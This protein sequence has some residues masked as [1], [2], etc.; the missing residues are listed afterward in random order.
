MLVHASNMHPVM[1]WIQFH[2]DQ[3]TSW[4]ALLFQQQHATAAPQ[5]TTH[6]PQLLVTAYGCSEPVT[7]ALSP[8]EGDW[9]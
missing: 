6:L 4:T 7:A 5:N 8:L 1:Q 9:L 3:N 2:A